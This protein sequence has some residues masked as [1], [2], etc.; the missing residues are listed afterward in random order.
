MRNL[1]SKTLLY[2]EEHFYD[3]DPMNC[4]YNNL[5]KLI[6]KIYFCLRIHYEVFKKT[7][8]GTKEIIRSINTK[9]ILFRNAKKLHCCFLHLLYY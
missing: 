9:T 6:L 1:P 4:H 8:Q 3:D 7:E 2:F 5:I